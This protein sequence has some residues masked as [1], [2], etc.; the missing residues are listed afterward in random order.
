MA[1]GIKKITESV[2][3]DGRALT[4]IG[5]NYINDNIAFNDNNAIDSG[6]IITLPSGIVRVKASSGK[7]VRIDADRSIALGSVTN[8]LIANNAIT[9]DKIVDGAIITNKI[10]DGAVTTNKI[11][12][13]Q[14]TYNKLDT[15][16]QN[17]IE[18][19]ES[20]IANIEKAI[21]RIDNDITAI[22]NKINKL[23]QTINNRID[24]LEETMEEKIN[25]VNIAVSQK[26]IEFNKAIENVKSELGKTVMHDGVNNIGNITGKNGSTNIVNLTC[27]GDIQG[28]RVYFM[29]YQDLAEAY[30]PGEELSAGDI[31][32]M[33]E[34]GKVYKAGPASN[35][36]VGVISDEFA[37]CFGATPE[38][39]E[40]KTK[41]PVGMIG[42]IHVKVKG[43]VQLGQQIGVYDN[44]I[45]MADSIG[46]GKA[47]ETI[48]CDENEI[49]TILV[50]VRP[51]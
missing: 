16:L 29:T 27:T 36:I 24:N 30:I 3:E 10:A 51:L 8:K 28:Q 41:V 14:I 1:I 4:M 47:L 48:E 20:K 26:F 49:H 39:L 42:K 35:C 43:S 15:S 37:N 40:S 23:D 25:A 19:M 22:S 34:D 31:V 5:A 38:E 45:G 9:T 44:G 32:A 50:Q 11:R 2:I 12:N 17:R 21:R 46:I 13:N 7:Q 6:A 18:T 33:H